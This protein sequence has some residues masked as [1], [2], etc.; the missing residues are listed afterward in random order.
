MLLSLLKRKAQLRRAA[1]RARFDF[2]AG[3]QLSDRVKHEFNESTTY[4]F[5][6]SLSPHDQRLVTDYDHDMLRRRLNAAILAWGHGTITGP[7][8]D[9]IAIGGS[10]GRHF[11]SIIDK[12]SAP[13][14]QDLEPYLRHQHW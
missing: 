3:R 1:D 13:T 2:K 9:T 6:Y 12:H 14:R 7:T 8:G 4:D 5:W 11:R 10:T